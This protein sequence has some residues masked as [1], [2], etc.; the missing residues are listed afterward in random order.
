VAVFIE[1]QPPDPDV[2][3]MMDRSND[4]YS[5]FNRDIGLLMWGQGVFEH[6][7][8]MT[9]N[10]EEWREKLAVVQQLSGSIDETLGG[11]DKAS[12]ARAYVAAV[13]IRDHWPELTSSE[14]DWCL[15]TTC[16]SI[17]A[18]CDETDQTSCC[19]RYSMSGD[20]PAAFVVSAL[21]GKQLSESQRSQV[22][23][24]LAMALTHG[25]DEVAEYAA[26][27][28]SMHLWGVD[29]QLA[30]RCINSLARQAELT[31]QLFDAERRKA[32]HER[33][34]FGLLKRDHVT[35]I[36][37][38]IE[39]GE[40]VDE[41]SY[42][43]FQT[44]GWVGAP[45]LVRVLLIAKGAPSEPVAVQLFRRASE[46]LQYW[47]GA[48]RRRRRRDSDRSDDRPHQIEPTINSLLERFVLQVAPE[49]AQSVLE[50]ILAEVEQNPREVSW[51]VRGLTSAEDSLFR[52]ANFWAIWEQFAS[53]IRTSRLTENID[54]SRYYS[55]DELMSAIF[56]GSWWKDEVRHWRSLDGYAERI[57]KLF[58]ALPPS[59]VILDDYVRFLYHIGEQ[60]LPYAFVHVA[61][62]LQ[63]GSPMQMLSKD[64]A[65]F[66]LESL[67]RRFVYGRPLE[68]K[69]EKSIREAVLYVLDRLV[70]AGSSAAYRMRDD[71]VT[72]VAVTN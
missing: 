65:V 64:N 58:L 32:Y 24:A 56:L 43:R 33:R 46:T 61:S 27:G 51:I 23:R 14:Q 69:R 13:C 12:S 49:D 59:A 20:R 62:R 45:A 48:D 50:P 44:T 63:A 4:E 42:A 66:M 11:I 71:F 6:N 39:G 36:R 60:S 68:T 9:A 22:I 57:H 2:Q 34:P 35:S 26:S 16:E 15:T 18:K 17:A 70:E 38:M 40:P 37:L 52:P 72:P 8:K 47:W 19:Q 41:Q 29:S 31:Q 67:L 3:E 28:A 53:R 25:I 30:I 5:A 1:M 7:E 10:P 54:D 21:C 55:G